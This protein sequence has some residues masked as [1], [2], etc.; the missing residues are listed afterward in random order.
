MHRDLE[1]MTTLVR[2]FCEK[3]DWTQFH[4]PKEL[5]IGMVTE[6]SE[7]LELFRFQNVDQMED[8]LNDSKTRE[9]I[10]DPDTPLMNLAARTRRRNHNG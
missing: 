5:A 9:H 8:M 4:T 3:R 7:L 2:L 1:A 6:A 10:G